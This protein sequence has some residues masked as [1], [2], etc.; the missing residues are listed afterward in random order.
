MTTLEDIIKELP[1]DYVNEMGVEAIKSIYFFYKH[2]A[3]MDIIK[4][5]DFIG[6]RK[7]YSAEECCK[8]LGLTDCETWEEVTEFFPV[9]ERMSDGAV[10]VAVD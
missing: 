1:A 6:W 9:W 5:E 7:Y 4:A 2:E 8:K 10:L 3:E